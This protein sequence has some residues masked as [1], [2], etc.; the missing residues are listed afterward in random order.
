[1]NHARLR[2]VH[3]EVLRVDR[4]SL[5]LSVTAG[6][7]A[8]ITSATRI[9]VPCVSNGGACQQQPAASSGAAVSAVASQQGHR[10][11]FESPLSADYGWMMDD[12]RPGSIHGAH[13]H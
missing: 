8:G 5:S 2:P 7:E 11:A 9:A 10:G 6:V 1:M 12:A 13:L 3:D 4:R